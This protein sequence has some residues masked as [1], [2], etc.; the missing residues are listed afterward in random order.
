M[1]NISARMDYYRS[2]FDDKTILQSLVAG[3]FTP[4][5]TEKHPPL[6]GYRD[7]LRE[8]AT[9]AVL[10]S[11]PH[12]AGMGLCVQ[13]GGT[14]LL[15]METL[16]DSPSWQVVTAWGL[17]EAKATRIDI[18]I[19]ILNAP[20]SAVEVKERLERGEAVTPFKRW[21]EV[22][23]G[24]TD[25]GYTLYVGSR[26]SAK[27]VR[28]YDKGAETGVPVDWWR[29]EMVFTAE[30]AVQ[31]WGTIAGIPDALGLLP[32]ARAMLATMVDFPKW[33]TWRAVMHGEADFQWAEIP[34]KE[35]SKLAWL[36]S[37]VA[38]TFIAAYDNDGDWRLLDTFV[39]RIKR[40]P[41]DM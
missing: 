14:A 12:S 38:P 27:S 16:Y 3:V 28:I 33:A 34:R 40:E 24:G 21:N 6:Y 1:T 10:L 30:R 31:A 18:A 32:V 11:N 5:N 15:N 36:M 20:F 8:K 13:A 39:S 17:R 19:D 26:S 2:V 9:G 22:K 41:V 23:G 29:Y 7:A 25:T 37:Q 35:S 4:A